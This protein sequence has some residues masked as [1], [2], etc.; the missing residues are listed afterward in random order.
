MYEE[1]RVNLVRLFTARLRSRA[2]AEDLVQELYFKVAAVEG[3]T[4]G[5]GGGSALLH[6]MAENLMLDRLRSRQRGQARDEHWRRLQ[7]GEATIDGDQAADAPSAESV[8]EGRQRL[9]AMLKTL[10]TLPPSV[11]RAFRLHKLEGLSHAETAA[12]MGVSR[13]AVEKYVSAA[14]KAVFRGAA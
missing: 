5:S 8:V 11:A 6:R 12:A 13:S 4:A 7:G 10:E 14:L 3:D 9:A 2:E 1:K